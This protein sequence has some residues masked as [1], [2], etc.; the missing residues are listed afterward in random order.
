MSMVCPSFNSLLILTF[1]PKSA[2]E[3]FRR[4]ASSAINGSPI[5]E[6][7]SL[8]EARTSGN[9]AAALPGSDAKSRE[10]ALADLENLELENLNETMKA[11]RRKPKKLVSK[12][13]EYPLAVGS[14]SKPSAGND[15]GEGARSNP[16]SGLQGGRP[17]QTP[18]AERE[19][20]GFDESIQDEHQPS[21]HAH[22]SRPVNV[23]FHLDSQAYSTMPSSP[24]YCHTNGDT[25]DYGEHIEVPVG[26]VDSR[27]MDQDPPMKSR[28]PRFVEQ[29]TI[30]DNMVIELHA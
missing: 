8:G 10:R 19:S 29:Q 26:F 6:G 5:I 23:A 12:E 14:W 16:F 7:R 2:L 28:N 13:I 27:A 20:F 3:R 22:Q 17:F 15:L 11:W 4:K 21:F 24:R 1:P 25:M 18:F 9:F 30:W